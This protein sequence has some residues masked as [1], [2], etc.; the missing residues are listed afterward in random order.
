[1]NQYGTIFLNVFKQVLNV[2]APLTETKVT[3]KKIKQKA[4]PWINNGILKLIRTK[5][6]SHNKFLKERI[7]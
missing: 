3:R 1:M 5:D 7:K 2:H 4:K 6:K